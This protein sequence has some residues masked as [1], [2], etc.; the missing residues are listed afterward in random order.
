MRN[1]ITIQGQ[2]SELQH[3]HK[4]IFTSLGIDIPKRNCKHTS[5]TYCYFRQIL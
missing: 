1:N 5:P 3:F 4:N 2:V